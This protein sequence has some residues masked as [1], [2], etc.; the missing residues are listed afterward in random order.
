MIV[1]WIS[2]ILRRSVLNILSR[3]R[4]PLICHLCLA[5]ALSDEPSSDTSVAAPNPPEALGE[6]LDNNFSMEL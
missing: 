4:Q 5:A 3:S 6:F 2:Q 1:G